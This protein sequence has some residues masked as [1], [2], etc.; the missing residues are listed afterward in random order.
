MTSPDPGYA[1]CEDAYAKLLIYPGSFSV[2]EVS[3]IL[4]IEF[5]SAQKKGE[6]EQLK[7][8]YEFYL[9]KDMLTREI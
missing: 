2:A 6:L 1:T 4:K 5:T 7:N 8:L 3:N 9:R